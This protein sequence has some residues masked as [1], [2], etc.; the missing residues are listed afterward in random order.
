MKKVLLA[1]AAL[2]LLATCISP[3]QQA[4]AA[5][6]ND[7]AP[8]AQTG[9][10][11]IYISGD[12]GALQKGVDWPI[13]RFTD[14]GKGTIRDNLT[15]LIWLKNANCPGTPAVWATALAYVTELNSSGTMNAINC[16]D[17]SKTGAVHQT[18]WRLPNVHELASL[19]DYGTFYPAL[20]S[21][22]P[23]TTFWVSFYWSSTSD[24][25]NAT[26]YAWGV[27]FIDGSVGID[28]KI[29]SNYVIAVRGG[30]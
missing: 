4:A 22:Y 26:T 27:N 6:D 2:A 30:S 29:G 23:F 3:A 24:A 16:G 28:N 15:K 13:P 18:D 10:T 7:N 9:Q 21:G 11:T 14:N 1:T 19:V 25:S 12:D 8:V 17:M 20:P 5:I